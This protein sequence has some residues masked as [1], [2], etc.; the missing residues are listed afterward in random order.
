MKSCCAPP[1][2]PRTPAAWHNVS[3][4]RPCRTRAATTPPRSSSISPLRLRLRHRRPPP[5]PRVATRS[6]ERAQFRREQP[7]HQSDG[8]AAKNI[9]NRTRSSKSAGGNSPQAAHSPHQCTRRRTGDDD[10]H[11]GV[12]DREFIYGIVSTWRDFRGKFSS[13]G[14]VEEGFSFARPRRFGTKS[15]SLMMRAWRTQ[16]NPKNLRPSP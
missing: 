8:N 7:D 15:P 9:S 14:R 3:W 4:S 10:R 16:P 5:D 6:E 12:H 2:R 13:A 11:V 1:F